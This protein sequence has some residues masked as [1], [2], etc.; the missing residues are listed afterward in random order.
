MEKLKLPFKKKKGINRFSLL[1]VE[2]E[3]SKPFGAKVVQHIGID[4]DSP[5]GI[6]FYTTS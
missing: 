4:K 3:I 2:P 6:Y 1:H 5:M